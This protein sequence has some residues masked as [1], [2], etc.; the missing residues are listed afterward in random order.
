MI[1]IKPFESRF[2]PQVAALI[3]HIQRV[4]NN[5]PLTLADQPDLLEIE[6]FYRKKNGNF[7]IAISDETTVVGTI[8]LIDSGLHFG[9]IRKMFVHADFRGKEKG[10]AA[11][12]L[13]E[14]E[15]WAITHDIQTLYLG[16]LDRLHAAMN[17]YTKNGYTLIEPSL[18][19]NTFPR[20]AVDNR[21][22]RKTI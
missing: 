6:A 16:T 17:F 19:P 13:A 2:Q 20:M 9:T 21:F 18:L 22:F 11:K 1:E 7:W 10:I 5:V 15:N 14:L 4:E 8:A 3:L 12:L